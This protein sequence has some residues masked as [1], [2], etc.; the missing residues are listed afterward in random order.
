MYVYMLVSKDK[1]ELPL[2]IADSAYELSRR[3][4]VK[5][6]TIC[7]AICHHRKRPE[8]KCQYH[9]VDIGELA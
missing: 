9:K 1:Y 8:G 3:I 7:S 5:E 4:G 2:V 6:K